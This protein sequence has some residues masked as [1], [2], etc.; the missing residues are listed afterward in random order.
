MTSLYVY[1]TLK[2][3]FPAKHVLHVE[4]N[5]PKALNAMNRQFWVVSNLFTVLNLGLSSPSDSPLLLISVCPHLQDAK[6]AFETA[7]V[8]PEVRAVVVSSAAR[9]FTAGLDLSEGLNLGATG[10]DHARCAMAI[11]AH[12]K[13]LQRTFTAMEKCSKPVVAVVHSAC[14]GGGVDLITACDIRICSADAWFQV[15]EVE[16]GLAADVGTL[17]R[18]PKIVGNDSIVRELCL[19]GSPPNN[20]SLL[21][22]LVFSL[23]SSTQTES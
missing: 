13:E 3:S 19:T 16:I 14:V 9:I 23:L 21:F 1:D 20:F 12:V 4:L 10:P 5:R 15:K 18:L 22:S 17:Q 7:H 6:S 8:D 2:C 11:A